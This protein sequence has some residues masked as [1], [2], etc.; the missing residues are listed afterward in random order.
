MSVLDNEKEL[1]R[2]ETLDNIARRRELADVQFI[3][4]SVEGRRFYWRLMMRC[5]IFKSS[6]TG[7]NT[8]FYN[9]GERNIGLLMMA[10]LNEA[11]PEAYIKCLTESKIQEASH[12]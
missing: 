1:K 4:N 3:L 12:G 8:T 5:G 11:D 10:D 9:E 2:K 7:N 6:M